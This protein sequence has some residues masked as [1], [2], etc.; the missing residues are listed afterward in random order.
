MVCNSDKDC[1]N[2]G[3]CIVRTGRKMC[4][5]TK[6]FT[7]SNCQNNE[8]HYGYGFDQENKTTSSSLAETNFPRIAIYILV[9]FL[10]G[11]IFGLI[12]H[13]RKLFRKL[14]EKNQQLRKNYQMIL[15]HESSRKDQI[16]P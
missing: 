13:I 8:Y 16:L 15:S 14:T 2:D 1:L 4:F 6:F 12:L 5:C 11:L 10:I 3:V 7:G 9:F